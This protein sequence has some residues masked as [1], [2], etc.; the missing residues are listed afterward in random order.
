MLIGLMMI[1]A[2]SCTEEF[3]IDV[4]EGERMIGVEAYFSNEMKQHEVVL[5]MRMAK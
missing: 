2:V 3:I 5:R 4:E 1:A